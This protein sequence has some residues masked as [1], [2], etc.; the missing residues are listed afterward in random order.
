MQKKKQAESPLIGF[1]KRM[2]LPEEVEGTIP[3]VEML[4]GGELTVE[5]H[6]G[7]LQYGEDRIRLTT[8]FGTLRIVGEKLTMEEFASDRVRIRGTVFGWYFEEHFRC[9]NP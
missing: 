2:N 9:G 8:R 6:T 5:N 3:K 1:L 4:G 7:I